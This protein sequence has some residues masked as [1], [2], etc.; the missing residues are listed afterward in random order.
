MWSQEKCF[1]FE[2]GAITACLYVGK[3]D[4]AEGKLMVMG[5]DICSNVLEKVCEMG[6]G[7]PQGMVTFDSGDSLIVVT[8]GKTVCEQTQ[9]GRS[10]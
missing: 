10:L 9:I 3:N 6:L 8:G 1:V 5:V 4:A 7:H 2:M